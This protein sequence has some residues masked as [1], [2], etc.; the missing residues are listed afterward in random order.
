VQE[1]L[2]RDSKG[3]ECHRCGRTDKLFAWDF[4]LAKQIGSRRAWSTTAASLAVS[5][6]TVPLFGIGRLDLPGKK[7]SFHVLR[8][9]ILLCDSCKRLGEVPYNLHPWWDDAQKLGY[10]EFLDAEHLNKLRPLRP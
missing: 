3:H 6:V 1:M 4:G 7:T 8:M 5:A 9:R 10:T 2:S